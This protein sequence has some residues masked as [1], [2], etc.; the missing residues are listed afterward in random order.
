MLSR[1][2]HLSTRCSVRSQALSS[3]LLAIAMLDKLIKKA[4]SAIYAR[5]TTD[6][7][8]A[9]PAAIV[10]SVPVFGPAHAASLCTDMPELGSIDRTPAAAL[11]GLP[12]VAVSTVAASTCTTCSSWR[13]PSQSASIPK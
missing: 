13:P 11:I 2:R 5:A 12:A 4:D 1:S 8:L 10:H 3:C 9:R 7:A 6:V